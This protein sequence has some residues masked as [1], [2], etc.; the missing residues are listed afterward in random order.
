MKA[1]QSNGELALLMIDVDHF[2]PFN[3]TY[4]HP[5]GDTCLARIGEALAALAEATGGFAAR[6]G[7]EEFC[8]LMPN[9]GAGRALEVGEMV[10]S[11]VQNL[12]IPHST[13]S[14][15]AVTVSVGVAGTR[16]NEGLRPSDLLEAADASLYA[17]KRNGRNTV[18]GHCLGQ[19]GEDGDSIALA[20]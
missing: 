2:K 3:D 20:S 1:Q 18:A 19:A 13:S 7:G 8:L 9:T 16:P 14:Y 10:R 12:L 6:Y 5:E 11:T 15:Q 17:A 4:G